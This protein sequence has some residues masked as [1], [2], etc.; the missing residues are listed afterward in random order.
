MNAH[1]TR[2]ASIT[3]SKTQTNVLP[4]LLE[5]PLRRSGTLH[6]SFPSLGLWPRNCN[7]LAERLRGYETGPRRCVM[8]H[9]PLTSPRPRRARLTP[10]PLQTQALGA[11]QSEGLAS[12]RTMGG[13]PGLRD[14][15]GAEYSW[16]PTPHPT[17]G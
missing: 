4:F 17:L 13:R 9:S 6:E 15:E 10:Q 2:H 5:R 7:R 14:D 16:A 12:I 11:R 3:E 8:G 1:R